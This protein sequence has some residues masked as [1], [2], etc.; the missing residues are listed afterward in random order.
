[1]INR[2]SFLSSAAAFGAFASTTPAATLAAIA[3]AQ[4]GTSM[5]FSLEALRARAAEMARNAYAPRPKVPQAWRDLSYDQYRLFWF[6]NEKA[7]WAKSN[8]PQRVDFFHPGLYFPRPVT[9]NVVENG[10]TKPVLFDLDLFDRTDKAPDLPVDKTLGFSGFRLRDELEKPGVFQEYM[11]FQGASYFRAHAKGQVYG[12]SARGLAL[13]TGDADGE[14]F[15]DFTD[16][17]IEAPAPGD[18]LTR[19]HALLD[20]PS[21]TGV[22]SFEVTGTDVI[23]TEVDARL[24]PRVPLEHAGIAPLTSMFFFDETNRDRFSD[25]R[26]AVHD[27]DGLLIRNGA[28][29]MLW[30]PLANPRDLQVSSFVDEN[31]QGFGLM[32]RPR[33]PE[34][35]ADFEAL[36]H[37]R[38]SVWVTPH[39]DW[40]TGVVRLVEIPTNREIYDN[41][42]AYWRPHEP[43]QPGVEHRY[44]YALHWGN[45]PDYERSV[46]KVINT[47]MGQRD[48]EPGYVTT[49]D[50]AD[51]PEFSDGTDGITIFTSTSRGSISDGILQPNPGTGGL[52]LGFSFDPGD[53]GSTEMRV[54]LMRDSKS[55]S[56]VWLY[57]WTA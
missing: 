47:R 10:M 43:L 35:F 5:A 44:T 42:V 13:K 26:P 39:E 20:S 14:E 1:M 19:I 52:R 7:L 46:A 23:K 54:Q 12:V 40:G 41:I 22:Y 38:P 9:V 57:R 37:K 53:A 2:R 27:S 21:T 45:E 6:N 50:F 18:S 55:I 8:R 30:R 33:N 4:L 36:Y 28:G 11:V 32:Q 25:F 49:I 16:F 29:E 51:H 17:W 56:E 15:P 34:D 24:Y 48:F 31:P 3:G